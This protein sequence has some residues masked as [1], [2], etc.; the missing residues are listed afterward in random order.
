[1]LRK[2]YKT[3]RTT[4]IAIVLHGGDDVDHVTN[5]RTFD[6]PPSNN[7]LLKTRKSINTTARFFS[8]AGL[9]FVLTT[10]T[11]Y[12]VETVTTDMRGQ[13]GCFV[14]FMGGIGVL[15]TFILGTWWQLAAAMMVSITTVLTH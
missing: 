2:T 10:T 13:P 1:M 4:L 15:A 7:I 14:Q 9:G 8:G 12:V 6:N 5:V 11:I 3:S